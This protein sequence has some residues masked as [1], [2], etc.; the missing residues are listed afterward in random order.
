MQPKTNSTLIVLLPVSNQFQLKEI[1]V[2]SCFAL[3]TTNSSCKEMKRAI[4]DVSA[5]EDYISTKLSKSLISEAAELSGKNKSSFF[6]SSLTIR[7]SEIAFLIATGL[8][9]GE[10]ARQLKISPNTVDTHRKNILKKL[11]LKNTAM[12]IH[13][14]HKNH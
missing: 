13:Y 8:N 1:V 11:G 2:K 9:S 14:I 6:I 4:E 7:E 10:I 3:L 12:L 5:G